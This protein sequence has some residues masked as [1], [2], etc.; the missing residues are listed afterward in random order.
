MKAELSYDRKGHRM[1]LVTKHSLFDDDFLFES[2]DCDV[3]SQ[4]PIKRHVC[5]T[6]RT[7]M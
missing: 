6:V 2:N 3:G 4:S 1:H 7:V 5:T